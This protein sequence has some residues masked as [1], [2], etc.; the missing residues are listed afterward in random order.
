LNGQGCPTCGTESAVNKKTK[1]TNE[2]IKEAKQ[3]H[4]DIYD[5]SET[6]YKHYLIKI[7]IICKKHGIFETIPGAHLQGSDCPTCV[8]ESK[9]K[10]TEEFIKE[11]IELHGDRYDYS[12][13]I[14]IN[15]LTKL[16]I[17]CKKHGIFKQIP[18]MHVKQKRG[19]PKCPYNG[20]SQKQ[21][22]WLNYIAKRDNIY[23]QHAMNDGEFRIGKYL[24]DGFCK[25]TNTV[26]EFHGDFFHGNPKFYKPFDINP[27]TKKMYGDL[28]ITT[29]EKAVYI[30]NQGYI[31]IMIWEYD[32]DQLVKTL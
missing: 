27:L 7:K 21:L 17:K 2:Y 20:F 23:I 11:A 32:W 12:C 1:S 13:T 28:Y 18:N 16:D 6:I 8:T 24:V 19:C 29:L 10:T 9:T 14:Y 22:D 25:E 4:G 3:V 15:A 31:L 30:M 26:Y 5:Y